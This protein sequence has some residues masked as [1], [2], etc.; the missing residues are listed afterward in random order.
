MAKLINKENTHPIDEQLKDKKFMANKILIV[1]AT[2]FIGSHLLKLL[3]KEGF[4]LLVLKRSYD[5]T[6]RINEVLD[7]VKTYNIDQTGLEMPFQ[8]NEVNLV[9]NLAT[10]FGRAT[11]ST[12]SKIFDT[13]VLF[14]LKLIEIAVENNVQY[15]FNIDS[16]LSPEVNLYA[17]TKKV[18]KYTIEKYFSSQIKIRNLR[19]E[20]VVGENDDLSKL[21]PFVISELK[22]N[23]ELKISK[24][25]QDLDFLYV[26]DCVDAFLYLI[27]NEKNFNKPFEDFQIG[28]GK[29]TKLR[30][31][32]ELIKK[33]IGSNSVICYGAIPYR[34]HE[35]MYSKADPSALKGWVP[36]YDIKKVIKLLVK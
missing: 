17:Y 27:K 33:E 13:N 35:Q 10:D 36:K 2:G 23:R 9:V 16:S 31:L 29:T 19:L 7:S 34:E 5:S 1:G 14:G 21:I 25:E 24:G 30:D 15:Y 6:K 4:D 28:T 3:V 18:F 11:D 8:E 20:Y 26:K 22:Q 32:I 12:P